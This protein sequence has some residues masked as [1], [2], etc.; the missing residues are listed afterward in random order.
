MIDKLPFAAPEDPLLKARLEGI[1]RR[2]GNPFQ[3][4]QLPQAV[5]ALKQGFGR[6]IRDREDFGVVMLCDPRIV[7]R[8]YGRLFIASLPPAPVVADE[9]E[10]TAFLRR[11]L[12]RAGLA[13]ARGGRG[14]TILAI[15]AATE[16]CSAALLVGDD[17]DRTLR[18]HRPRPRRP[19]VADGGRAAAGGGSHGRAIS[20]PLHSAADPADSP[21][22]ESRRASHRASRPAP[23]SPSCPSATSRPSRRA[24]RARTAGRT[25][26]SAWTRAWARCTGPPSIAAARARAR[27][28]ASTC[29][30]P[31]QS[32][33]PAGEA[34]FGAGHGFSAYPE[35]AA[36]LAG[37]LAG[38]D[39]AALPRAG[40]IARIGA[41]DLAA[42]E[43]LAAA[44]GL[45]V[46]LRD[47][48]VHRR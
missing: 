47:D 42:G 35:L 37:S 12:A 38:V 46:Y 23:A 3:E 40:D 41:V 32:S 19:A 1:R 44:Q 2:G 6:L 28:R 10:A 7:T 33:R 17:D 43:G 14:M 29:R 25:S 15:D 11:Q 39:D 45:P 16:A 26:S 5:L 31:A 4:F 18:S 13:P 20:T 34:M 30:I 24:P 8:G 36:R 22:F 48:V 27:S 9:D 21:A